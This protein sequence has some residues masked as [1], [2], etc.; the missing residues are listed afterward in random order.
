MS[1]YV[2]RHAVVVEDD[3]F[4]QK[5]NEHVIIRLRDCP[6]CGGSAEGLDTND[7]DGYSKSLIKC[8]K[9]GAQTAMLEDLE[10]AADAWNR[11]VK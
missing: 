5:I 4:L 7:A 8:T 6:F 9:C 2:E 1:Q 3:G 11:R 10:H